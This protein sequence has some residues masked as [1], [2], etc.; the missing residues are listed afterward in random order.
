[1]LKGRW[2]ALEKNIL[3]DVVMSDPA[4]KDLDDIVAYIKLKLF[5]P[6]AASDFAEKFAST[7]DRLAD[8]PYLYAIAQLSHYTEKTYRRFFVNNYVG[9]YYVNPTEAKVNI[10]RIFSTRQNYLNK[11]YE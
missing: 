7:I 10:V 2:V 3:F 4:T 6:K 5:N 9:L 11:F 8:S 1:M